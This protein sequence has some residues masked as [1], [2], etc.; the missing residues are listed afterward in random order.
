GVE[1]ALRGTSTLEC[2]HANY[3]VS[4]GAGGQC[5]GNNGE[6]MTCQQVNSGNYASANCETG[7][8]PVSGS[9]ECRVFPKDSSD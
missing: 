5:D 9:G 1:Y 4:D 3:E 7:C 6:E 2:A 8:G